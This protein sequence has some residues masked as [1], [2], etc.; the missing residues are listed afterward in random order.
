MTP[1]G[2]WDGDIPFRTRVY[3]YTRR[4]R[5]EEEVGKKKKAK[6]AAVGGWRM[7]CEVRWDDVETYGR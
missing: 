6:E 1:F 3:R 7:V 5:E 4:E 2:G